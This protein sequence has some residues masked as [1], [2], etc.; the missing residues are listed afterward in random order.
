MKPDEIVKKVVEGELS[1]DELSAAMSELSVEDQAEVNRLAKES[2][3][4]SLTEASALRKERDRANDMKTQAEKDAEAAAAR[5]KAIAEGKDPDNPEGG[6]GKEPEVPKK[7]DTMSQFR[8]EQVDKAKN[9]FKDAFSHLEAEKI[10]EVFAQFE[11]VDSGKV[12][13][14][15]IY[16]DLIGAYAFI[17]RDSLVAAETEKRQREAN[18]E[19]DRIEGARSNGGSPKDGNQP[20]KVKQAVKQV[21]KAAGISEEAAQ[22]VVTE[23]NTR[24]YQ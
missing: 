5:A 7:D 19:E 10:N 12:D 8:K 15:N 9:R 16:Q 24:T 17:N 18:A 14:D 11:H 22:K 23:G 13:A 1:G 3:A 20:E 6:Q 21:A 2:A 4:T